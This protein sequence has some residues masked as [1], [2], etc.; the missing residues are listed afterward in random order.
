[1]DWPKAPGRDSRHSGAFEISWPYR[2]HHMM[3]FLAHA[4]GDAIVDEHA[5]SAELAAKRRRRGH[6]H[7]PY[8]PFNWRHP[9]AHPGWRYTRSER[10][11]LRAATIRWPASRQDLAAYANRDVLEA[12]WDTRFTGDGPVH[13]GAAALVWREPNA[14]AAA[15]TSAKSARHSRLWK[16]DFLDAHSA[17]LDVDAVMARIATTAHRLWR[18]HAGTHLHLGPT[19]TTTWAALLAT[20]DHLTDYARALNGR[21]DLLLA[22][23]EV[24]RLENVD[25]AAIRIEFGLPLDDTTPLNRSALDLDL[26]VELTALVCQLARSALFDEQEDMAQSS[27]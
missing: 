21:A 8:P 15:F 11:A 19:D 1:M 27:G 4:T 26:N 14:V 9:A 25:D 22:Y 10:R 16:T 23:R 3:D 20:V 18:T 12:E 17:R 13:A 7:T 24:L 6:L 5:L 2:D